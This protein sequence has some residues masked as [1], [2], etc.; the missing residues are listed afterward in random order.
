MDADKLTDLREY[1]RTWLDRSRQAADATP[2]VQQLSEV[3]DWEVRTFD[4]RPI[5]AKKISM[6]DL[7]KHAESVY[8]RITSFLPMIPAIPPSGL[9]QITSLSASTSYAML[10]YVLDVSHLQT[11]DAVT[12]ASNTLTEYRQLQ[13]SQ[14][15]PAHVRALLA[16]RLPST[17]ARFDSARDTYQHCQSGLAD[18]TA[19]ALEMRTF[20]D[21]V[22]G[23]LFE[24][25]RRQPGE[26]MTLEL[27]LERLFSSAPA[28]T[29][30]EEQ[31]VQRPSLMEA[32]SAVA[33]RRDLSKAYELEALWARVLNHAFVV[34]SALT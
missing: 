21:G 8:G 3:V 28:R 33:K 13:E 31:F 23:E 22:K 30:I 12:Y 25:A 32:L 27:A 4:R 18:K 1:L 20:L 5:V 10:T 19:P 26:N 34:V 7:D 17:V 29:D 15:R 14:E 9:A 11:P 24:R 6:T 16:V 2:T